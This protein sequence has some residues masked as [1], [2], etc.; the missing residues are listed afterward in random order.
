MYAGMKSMQAAQN[1]TSEFVE[2]ALR[3]MNAMRSEYEGNIPD[4]AIIGKTVNGRLDL[5]TAKVA[6]T[7]EVLC[8][9]E[10]VKLEARQ[11]MGKEGSIIMDQNGPTHLNEGM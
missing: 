3:R 9:A 1:S 4:L 6:S 10:L 8:M 11:L 7:L 2:T 5:R